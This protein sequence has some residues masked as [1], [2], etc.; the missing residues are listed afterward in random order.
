MLTCQKQSVDANKNNNTLF[1][2]FTF[3][4]FEAP[5]TEILIPIRLLEIAAA[6]LNSFLLSSWGSSSSVFFGIG[7]LSLLV[8][9][10]LIFFLVIF[11][12]F[13]PLHL[14]SL[15]QVDLFLEFFLPVILLI[16]SF[17]KIRSLNSN[18]EIENDK[19]SKDN[20]RDKECVEHEW[21]LG[22]SY[23]VHHVG[24]ALERDDLKDIHDG[25]QDVVKRVSLRD[26]VPVVFTSKQIFHF[27]SV[28]FND[29]VIGVAIHI[30][31]TYDLD[32]L[33]S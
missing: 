13:V 19:R 8:F 17:I 11:L 25:Q 10:K 16:E 27:L 12:H 7:C 33:Y 4:D 2:R 18:H 1:E 9:L 5:L 20:A 26:R 6:G 29:M 23:D 14:E 22:V 31:N 15:L 32:L 30:C 3:T 21:S 24:P 28:A